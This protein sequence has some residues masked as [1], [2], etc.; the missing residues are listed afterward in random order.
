LL[1][2][3]KTDKMLMSAI[4][5][6]V[7]EPEVVT[8]PFTA[9]KSG[10]CIGV[11][12]PPASAVSYVYITENGSAHS[13]GYTTGGITYTLVFPVVKGKTY[14]IAASANY[15]VNPGFRLYPIVGGGTN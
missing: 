2:Q 9:T 11:V 7:G 14:S 1:N 12:A 10:I 5:K 15:S 3:K 13:R 4:E 8:F 6:A